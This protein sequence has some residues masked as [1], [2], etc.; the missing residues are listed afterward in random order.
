MEKVA[1]RWDN[2]FTEGQSVE[3]ASTVL[4]ECIRLDT[5]K[6]AAKKVL[7]DIEERL[8]NIKERVK[9]LFISMGVKSIKSGGR[10]VYLSKQI[11]AGINADVEKDALANVLIEADMKDYITCNS[12]KLSSYV[13][14]I[15]QEHPEFLNS[16]GD[17]I[18]SP[19]EIAAALPGALAQM[20]RVSE[21]IDIRIKK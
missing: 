17:I 10:N 11:W 4:A 7:D 5:E 12:T 9:D 15:V 13:R 2:P 14:E 8:A 19:E 3:D 18:A 21:K 6:K 1:A 16:D 20:V